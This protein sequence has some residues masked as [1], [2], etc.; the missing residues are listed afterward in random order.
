MTRALPFLWFL[1]AG[2]GLVASLDQVAA[3]SSS[4]A[5]AAAALFPAVM[6]SLA[7][8]AMGLTYLFIARTRPS[9]AVTIIGFSHLFLAMMARIGQF[10]AD[11]WRAEAMAGDYSGLSGKLGFAYMATGLA[12]LCGWIVF[13]IALIVAL[14]TPA[15]RPE[16]AF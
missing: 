2:A 11:S 13:V 4:P 7:A 14:N 10:L 12:S 9:P 1:L 5:L 8:L 3:A 15:G 6:A 16:D